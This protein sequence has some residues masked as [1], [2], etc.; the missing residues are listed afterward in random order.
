MSWISPFAL[1]GHWYRGN[2]HTH[3]TQSDGRSTPEAVSAWYRAHGYDFLAITDHWVHTRGMQTDDHSFITISGTELDG[4]GYHMLALGTSCLPDAGLAQDVSALVQQVLQQGGL[5]FFAHPYWTGQRYHSLIGAP[6]VL[7]IEVFNSVC[8]VLHGLGNSRTQWDEALS[9]GARLT[10]LAVDDWHGAANEEG[11]GWVMVRAEA[12]EEAAILRA[13]R[14]GY[15][16]AST[17]P[18]ITDLRL[19]RTEQDEPALLVRCEPCKSITFYGRMPSGYRFT[20]KPGGELTQAVFRLNANQVYLRVECE[21]NH[22]RI[23]WT[24]PVYLADVLES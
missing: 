16:Y 10:A 21:D 19:V 4:P 11:L 12:L 18:V 2:L 8:E 20:A 3:T 1:P 15:F 14:Q 9:T 17:G 13:L 6:G 5:P 23:A 24:N 7:G 22:G